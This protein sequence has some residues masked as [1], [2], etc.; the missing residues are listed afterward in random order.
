MISFVRLLLLAFFCCLLTVPVIT[1]FFISTQ[2]LIRHNKTYLLLSKEN[3]A[4]LIKYDGL[5][6]TGVIVQNSTLSKQFYIDMFGCEDESF[7]RPASLPYPGAFLRFG[8]S[9]IHLM[10]LPNMDPTIGRP[11]HGGRDRHV[12]LTVNDIDLIRTRYDERN[13]SYTFSQSG[14]R[15]LFVRDLDGNAFEFMENKQ[16]DD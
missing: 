15:A 2:P 14:R 4:K 13:L 10:E 5:H 9:E 8:R 12:A 7:R 1:S 6:H 16:L 11:I 3:E